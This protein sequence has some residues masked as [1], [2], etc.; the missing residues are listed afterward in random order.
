MVRCVQRHTIGWLAIAL[1]CASCTAR[2]PK[3]STPS[4]IKC[5]AVPALVELAVGVTIILFAG[6]TAPDPGEQHQ[7]PDLQTPAIAAA[8]L[9]FFVASAVSARANS[10]CE[11]RKQKGERA[12][13]E[14]EANGL[15]RTGDC[16]RALD[17]AR[18]QRPPITSAPMTECVTAEAADHAACVAERTT[19][20]ERAMEETDAEKR[21]AVLTMMVPCPGRSGPQ[22]A[23]EARWSVLV[24]AEV[25]TTKGDC[26]SAAAFENTL[27]INAPE[28]TLL[29]ADPKLQECLRQAKLARQAAAAQ[30]ELARQ[31]AEAVAAEERRANEV[32]RIRERQAC[33]VRRAEAIRQVQL[34][35]DIGRRQHMAAALPVCDLPAAP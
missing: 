34:E 8:S 3:Q 19:A 16:R 30:A 35:V 18:S 32:R 33:V 26:T 9:P 6:I 15:A 4:Q 2:A 23:V 11:S 10:G 13:L 12:R 7:A 22:L 20:F 29:D 5:S 1:L 24:Q 14:N 21:L 27:M 17:V 28:R 25:A 31:A